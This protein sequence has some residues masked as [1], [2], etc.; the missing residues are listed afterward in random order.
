VRRLG[1]LLVL[2]LVVSACGGSSSPVSSGRITVFAASSLSEAFRTLAA[3]Y[4]KA[5][6]GAHVALSFAGSQSLVAQVQQGA[7]ADVIATADVATM[8]KVASRLASPARVFA[9]NRLAI[10]YVPGHPVTSLAALARPG[11]KVVIGAPSVPVGKVTRAALAAA[12]VVL[13]PVSMEPDVKSVL[14][15]VVTGEAD[16]G[17]VYATDLKSAGAKVGGVVLPSV[18]TK[19]EVGAL[20]TSGQ[21]FADYVL[22]AAGRDVLRTSGFVLP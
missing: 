2:A 20:T 13:H 11:R 7:P 3:G 16:A 18:V 8:S 15:K 12:H 5:H 1:G 19:L 4:E 17:V 14:A 9:R 6:P 10:V 21:P 22:S